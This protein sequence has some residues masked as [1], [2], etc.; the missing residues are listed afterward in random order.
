MTTGFLLTI[1]FPELAI[2]FL[3]LLVLFGGA[4]AGL[5]L[6]RGARKRHDR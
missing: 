1:G 2:I 6:W 3:A 4:V 5:V